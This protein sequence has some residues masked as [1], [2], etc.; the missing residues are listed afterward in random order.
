MDR[1]TKDDIE[2]F[3]VI[4]SKVTELSYYISYGSF[5]KVS[6][7]EKT[8]S[9]ERDVITQGHVKKRDLMVAM[10][11]YLNG[12]QSGVASIPGYTLETSESMQEDI[13]ACM[14]GFNVNGV[15]VEKVKNA[16]CQIIVDRREYNVGAENT[17]E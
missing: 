4:M 17:K 8:N 10:R 14:E 16:L 12:W 6:L 15:D 7:V 1:V 5:G 11:A 13:L 2:K 9:S 3:C